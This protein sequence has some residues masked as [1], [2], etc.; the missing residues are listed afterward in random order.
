MESDSQVCL[1]FTISNNLNLTKFLKENYTKNN[2]E[3]WF[4]SNNI[5]ENI[6]KIIPY[7]SYEEPVDKSG[8]E[9]P[10]TKTSK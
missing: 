6:C 9:S 10:S 5:L 8:N 3:D 2:Y 7:I 4:R 1:F